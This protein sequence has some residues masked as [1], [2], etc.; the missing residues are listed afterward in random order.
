MT[1]FI[2]E[3]GAGKS[4]FIEALSLLAGARSSTDVIGAYGDF[5]QIEGLFEFAKNSRAHQILL[6]NEYLDDQSWLFSRTLTKAG[7][8]IYRINGQVTTLQMVRD[9][10]AEEIDIHSQFDSQ[11]LLQTAHQLSLL[12]HFGSHQ[13]LRAQVGKSYQELTKIRK[14][15]KAFLDQQLSETQ[16]EF[17]RFQLDELNQFNPSVEEEQQLNQ[18][19]KSLTEIYNAQKSLLTA[20]QQL[21]TL[22]IGLLYDAIGQLESLKSESNE[23]TTIIEILKD[24]YFSLEEATTQL[25][26]LL[27]QDIEEDNLDQLQA[28]LYEYSRMKRKYRVDTEGLCQL[29]TT[30]QHQLSQLDDRQFTINEFEK[31][32]KLAQDNYNELASKLSVQRQQTAKRLS[33]A[34]IPHLQDLKLEKAQFEVRFETVES[35]TGIDAI[36]FFVRMNPGQKF[37]SLAKTASGGEL[38]RLMLALKTVFNES[39]AISTLIFDEIDSGVS[40]EVALQMGL[41]MRQLAAHSQIIVVSHLPAVAATS[42]RLY[43][44]SKSSDDQQTEVTIEQLNS[45]EKIEQ[46]ALMAFAST[47]PTAIKAASE[48]IDDVVRGRHG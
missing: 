8:S 16:L 31:K 28:R 11:Q 10:L 15:Y 29:Q 18:Q 3:T 43:L 7:R 41:K 33:A 45:T 19:V 9:V 20:S 35:E 2:G 30:I 36:E 38:S 34:L 26:Q 39:H 14:E 27:K 24:S 40:G 21:E 46:I 44:I 17:L 25:N 37:T 12:D 32:R 13:E 42:D 6:E 1:V 47:Q 5:V 4:I 23:I 22:D 48:L